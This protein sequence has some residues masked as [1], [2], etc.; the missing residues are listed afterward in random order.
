MCSVLEDSCPG[1]DRWGVLKLS[2]V[3]R[4]MSLQEQGCLLRRRSGCARPHLIS[5]PVY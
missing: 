2:S 4:V 3:I 5:V 1:A